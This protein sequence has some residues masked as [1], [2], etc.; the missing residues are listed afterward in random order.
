MQTLRIE[1]LAAARS[2]DMTKHLDA[3]VQAFRNRPLDAGPY[4]CLWIDALVVRVRED[5]RSQPVSVILTTAVNR[6]GQPEILGV[7]AVIRAQHVNAVVLGWR[8][9]RVNLT[10]VQRHGQLPHMWC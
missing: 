6:D 8:G 3:V 2:R 1:K 10:L 4:T 7:R 5:S 9:D